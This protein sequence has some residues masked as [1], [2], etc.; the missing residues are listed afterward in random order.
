MQYYYLGLPQ[1]L[2]SKVAQPT[3]QKTSYGSTQSKAIPSRTFLEPLHVQTMKK[4]MEHHSGGF[5]AQVRKW[6]PHLLLHS[7]G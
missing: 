6:G 1:W 7:V 3:M 4:W 5:R 2:S